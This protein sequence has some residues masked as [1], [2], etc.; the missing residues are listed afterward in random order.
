MTARGMLHAVH[1]LEVIPGAIMVAVI[2]AG[3]TGLLSRR[4]KEE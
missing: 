1:V 4:H 3:F 2:V